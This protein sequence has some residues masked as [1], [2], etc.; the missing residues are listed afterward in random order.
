[1][2]RLHWSW[3]LALSLLTLLFIFVRLPASVFGSIIAAKT[4]DKF[5]LAGTSGSIW[6][7][8]GQPVVEGQALA[9]QLTWQWR[10]KDLLKA[11]LGYD[12][13]LDAG[14][15]QLNIGLGGISLRNADLTV[16]ASPLFKLAERTRAYGLTGQLR[17]ATAEMHWPTPQAESQLSIDWR[18]AGSSLAPSVPVLGD[19]RIGLTPSG[20]AWQLQLST[21]NGQLVLNGSGKWQASEGLAADITLQAAPGSG[22]ALVPFLNQV[23][24]GS[25]EAERRLRFNFR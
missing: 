2:R 15:A 10:P 1:M 14:Q 24:A 20:K 22:P 18:G 3:W 4:G 17:L 5:V 12:L 7:G 23:G 6:Q 25:P 11:S 8:T 16:A 19:Y 13:K 21:L 9:E